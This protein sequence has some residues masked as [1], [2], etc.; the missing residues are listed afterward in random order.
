M[1]TTTGPA[2]IANLR[3]VAILARL[4][5]DGVRHVDASNDPVYGYAFPTLAAMA[6][7]GLVELSYARQDAMA[8]D[9]RPYRIA[10]LTDAGRA[11]Y[12]A[13]LAAEAVA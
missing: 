3:H 9:P 5:Q 11:A 7:R 12:A 13:H 4:H 1:P 6:R 2:L 10:R 8:G